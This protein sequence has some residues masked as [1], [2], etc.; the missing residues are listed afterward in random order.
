MSATLIADLLKSFDVGYDLLIWIP[1]LQNVSMGT[2]Q[3]QTEEM[4]QIGPTAISMVAMGTIEQYAKIKK[5]AG[6]TVEPLRYKALSL[7]IATLT[8]AA[9]WNGQANVMNYLA[10]E[11]PELTPWLSA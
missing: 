3:Q 11:K 6:G 1:I 5:L 4:E 9:F 2:T 8:E 7:H 10:D